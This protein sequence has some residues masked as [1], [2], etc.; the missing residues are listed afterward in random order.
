MAHAHVVTVRVEDKL[1]VV[2]V[3]CVICEV[4]VLFVEVTGCRLDVLLSRQPSQTLPEHVQ[5]KGV[6]SAEQDV[7]PEVELQ[8]VQEKRAGQVTLN[9]I[10]FSILEII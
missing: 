8:T 2:L 1:R 4:H 5:P 3:Y 10:V 9:H 6:R 7:N